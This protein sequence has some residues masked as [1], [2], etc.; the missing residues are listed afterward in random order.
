MTPGSGSLEQRVAAARALGERD[1]RIGAQVQI[2]AGSF[3]AGD[4]PAREDT[5]SYQ[6][7]LVA[8]TVSQFAKFI[9]S[10]YR[11]RALWSEEGWEWR[12]QNAIERPR[13]WGEPD[14]S[15]YLGPSHP[16][17]GVSS[18]EAEAYASFAGRRLPTELEWERAARGEDGRAFPWGDAWDPMLAHHRGGARH[19]L[20]VGCFPAGASP[21]GLLDCAGNVWEW[22]AGTYEGS[23]ALR[24]ARGGAWNAHPP[25]LACKSRNAWPPDAR[26]SN[27]GFRTAR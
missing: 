22:C 9:E 10:G 1:P 15:A 27:I 21:H 2:A 8:V 5:E 23:P 25:Q 17:V 3:L 14:W 24:P 7:D 16:V 12:W 19:T 4:Q 11:E 20:P 18:Y 26:F 13:F 6:I